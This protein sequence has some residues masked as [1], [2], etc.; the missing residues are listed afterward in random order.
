M[1]PDLVDLV[2]AFASSN[3]PFPEGG[4]YTYLHALDAIGRALGPGGGWTPTHDELRELGSSYWLRPSLLSVRRLAYRRNVPI[5]DILRGV[6]IVQSLPFEEEETLPSTLMPRP[7]ERHLDPTELKRRFDEVVEESADPLLSVRAIAERL[8]VSPGALNY[9]CPEQV[10][11]HVAAANECRVRLTAERA[12]RAEEAVTAW[13]DKAGDIDGSNVPLK[14]LRNV[15]HAAGE[16]SKRE[17]EAAVRAVVSQALEPKSQPRAD[18]IGSAGCG[19]RETIKPP[20]GQRLARE[21][22]ENA[23]D[24]ERY[25]REVSIAVR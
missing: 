23:I 19:N 20:V 18:P 1:A 21:Y 25:R 24:S 13:L 10:K 17:L 5:E 8:G 15:L 14:P 9:H 22:G 4:A 6:P 16:F 12:Q 3:E 11:A 7:R 2:R